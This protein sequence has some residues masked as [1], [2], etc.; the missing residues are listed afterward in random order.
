MDIMH[1]LAQV[2]VEPTAV[3]QQWQMQR[4]YLSVQCVGGERSR[5]ARQPEAAVEPKHSC[6]S[7]AA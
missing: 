1:V 7:C 6:M 2:A 5:P 4:D 3:L